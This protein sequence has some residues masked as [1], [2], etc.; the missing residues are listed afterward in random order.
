MHKA[1]GQAE[2]PLDTPANSHS[3]KAKLELRR[4]SFVVSAQVHQ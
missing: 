3:T 2:P 4:V 1:V